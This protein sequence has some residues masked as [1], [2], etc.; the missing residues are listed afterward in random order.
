MRASL[1]K[2]LPWLPRLILGLVRIIS[3]CDRDIKPPLFSFFD[4]ISAFIFYFFLLMLFGG[5]D[6]CSPTEVPLLTHQSNIALCRA[7]HQ[8]QVPLSLRKVWYPFTRFD[9]LDI[10][11]QTIWWNIL[12]QTIGYIRYEFCYI[13]KMEFI[14]LTCQMTWQMV[15]DSNKLYLWWYH[16]YSICMFCF[17]IFSCKYILLELSVT[18]HLSSFHPINP[19]R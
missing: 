1:C 12:G 9:V 17:S 8:L 15:N 5:R 10:L 14:N 11:G 6:W 16:K 3:Y 7:A 18:I 19:I 4:I 2:K 13:H